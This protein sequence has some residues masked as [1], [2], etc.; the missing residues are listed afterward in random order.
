MAGQR[1]AVVKDEVC[2]GIE[3]QR[4]QAE[5]GDGFGLA[6]G[7]EGGVSLFGVIGGGL[8]TSKTKDRGAVCGMADAGEGE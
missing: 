2:A 5:G 4:G 1:G 3:L 6:N 7:G 8:K